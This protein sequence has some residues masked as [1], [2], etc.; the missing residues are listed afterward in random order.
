MSLESSN[1]NSF[2]DTFFISCCDHKYILGH[3]NT[4]LI[5]K[6]KYFIRD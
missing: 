2:D 1:F 6:S 3:L 4:E 5:I